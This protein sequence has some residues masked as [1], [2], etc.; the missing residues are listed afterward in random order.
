VL[1]SLELLALEMA[2]RRFRVDPAGDG[3]GEMAAYVMKGRDKLAM[4]IVL[5]GSCSAAS[6]SCFSP[7]S[8][9]GMKA[10]WGYPCALL[11]SLLPGA[12]GATGLQLDDL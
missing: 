4:S 1:G 11:F 10:E 2:G 3:W 5:A 9:A 7:A 6:S 8:P 12:H